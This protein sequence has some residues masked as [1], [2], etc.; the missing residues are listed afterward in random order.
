MSS[1]IPNS[2]PSALEYFSALVADDATLSLL[3]AAASIGLDESPQLDLQAVLAEVDELADRLKRR[4][5]A[6][7]VPLQRLR[8]LNGYFFQELGFS[9]NVNNYYDP[10]NSY[11][12]EV[13]RTRR[14]IPIT[15]AVLYVELATQLGLHAHGVSFPG[16]FLV[17]VSRLNGPGQ[18][19]AVIDPFSGKSLSRSELDERLGPYKISQGLVGDFDAPLGLFLQPA[20]PREVLARMLRNLKEI[21]TSAEDWPR[22]LQV[23]DRLIVLL[24]HAY[25][26][27]R[28][29][30]R[31]WAQLGQASKAAEDFEAYLRDRPDADDSRAMAEQLDRLR[32]GEHPRLH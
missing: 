7:M 16:H 24:P 26:E 1:L 11:L 22:L 8:R 31:V 32:R 4:I 15:L 5:P 10:C 6:D 27:R 29:R 9:G 18:G 30:G 12:H 28:D 20:P 17:K 21:H 25:E 14:G 2:A 19:E 23:L 13:L 3:E